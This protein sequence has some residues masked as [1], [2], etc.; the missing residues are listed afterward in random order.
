MKQQTRSFSESTLG[1]IAHSK[2]YCP[3]PITPPKLSTTFTGITRYHFL[4]NEKGCDLDR[5]LNQFHFYCKLE[6]LTDG[7]CIRAESSTWL[8]SRIPMGVWLQAVIVGGFSLDKAN[9]LPN[10]VKTGVRIKQTFLFG[11]VQAVMLTV[12]FCWHRS[13]LS[14]YFG[15]NV[16]RQ[17]WAQKPRA[18]KAAIFCYFAQNVQDAHIQI[19]VFTI[20]RKV[21]VRD[22][23]D[24]SMSPN[25]LFW[26][27]IVLSFNSERLF[28]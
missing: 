5:S 27:S 23:K 10:L 19:H 1:S 26:R 13:R 25:S 8:M 17:S 11:M 4:A 20:S 21:Q 12:C 24:F 6:Y 15:Q 22:F 14:C 16:H 28:S 3:K 18:K 9:V 7:H 2:S